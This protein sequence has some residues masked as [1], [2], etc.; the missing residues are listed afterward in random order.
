LAFACR[1]VPVPL[2]TTRNTHITPQKRSR[3]LRCPVPPP[4]PRLFRSYL[5]LSARL[6]GPPAI[7]RDFRTIDFL[8]LLDLCYI[9]ERVR[10]RFF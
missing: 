6:C 2:T 3:N 7:D 8:T 10:A 4:T 9:P 1:G 5:E